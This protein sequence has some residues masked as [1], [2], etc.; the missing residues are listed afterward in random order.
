MPKISAATVAEHREAQTRALIAA[1]RSV[2]AETGTKPSL[3]EVAARAGL[4]RSSVYQYFKSADDLL[5]AVVDDIFPRWQAL[6]ESEMQAA[7]T[8]GEKILT[9]VY[10]NLKLVDNGE[11][12]VAS[13]LHEVEPS[14]EITERG[15][16]MHRQ[17]AQ[18]LMEALREYGVA[19]IE[20]SAALITSVMSSGISLLERGVP[21]AQ[22][23]DSIE[24]LLAVF[25]R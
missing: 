19:D 17:L 6:I 25:Q 14:P 20:V 2:F 1:A 18:P 15:H 13:A 22:V 5:I 24:E 4:A 9:Y 23:W 16:H 12:A 3:A 21:L 7:R 10:A 11:H 8:P